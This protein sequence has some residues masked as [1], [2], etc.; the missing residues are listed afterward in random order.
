MRRLVDSR[1]PLN[2]PVVRAPHGA[3]LPG[4]PIFRRSP[5]DGII[6]IPAVVAIRFEGA[7]RVAASAH[8]HS[9]ENIT[10]RHEEAHD[11]QGTAAGLG[12]RR[13]RKYD[14]ETSGTI[15]AIYIG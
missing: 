8:V 6:A 1:E 3:D 11:F 15:W 14:W 2:A 4:R 13:A 9:H 5:F 12:V 10:A 7:I